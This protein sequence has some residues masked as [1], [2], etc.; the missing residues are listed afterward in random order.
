MKTTSAIHYWAA[1]L[2]ACLSADSLS[3]PGSSQGHGPCRHSTPLHLPAWFSLAPSI[4]ALLS[5]PVAQEY[6]N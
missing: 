3:I 5:Q 2:P 6:D 4:S 1:K